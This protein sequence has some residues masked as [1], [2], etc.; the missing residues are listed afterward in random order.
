M[1]RN[2]SYVVG[3]SMCE[4]KDYS[5]SVALEERFFT[6]RLRPIMRDLFL[7]ILCSL[8]HGLVEGSRQALMCV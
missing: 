1:S 4:K 2:K 3:L 5:M 8:M 7:L 6:H